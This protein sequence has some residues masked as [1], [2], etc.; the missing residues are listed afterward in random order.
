[1]E[2]KQAFNRMERKGL[3]EPQEQTN[4]ETINVKIPYELYEKIKET[5]E[6]SL[7]QMEELD[8]DSKFFHEACHK[9]EQIKNEI[10]ALNDAWLE[11]LEKPVPSQ[12][13]NDK[14]NITVHLSQRN[15]K[16]LKIRAKFYKV[17]PSVLVNDL[18]ADHITGSIPIVVE[19]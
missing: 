11:H 14:N 4:V 18:V 6:F 3:L 13:S 16:A 1:M 2:L 9:V 5:P 17:E 7:Y 12:K 8:F 15:L 19:K 10:E